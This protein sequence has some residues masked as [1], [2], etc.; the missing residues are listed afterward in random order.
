VIG[1]EISH[2]RVVEK[3]GE[4]GMGIVFKAE[5]VKLHR[6]VALKFLPPHLTADADAVARFE[7]EARAAAALNHPN[8]IGVY[9][10][11]E[12]EGQIYICMEYLEGE[13]LAG[14]LKGGPLPAERAAEIAVQIGAGLSKAHQVGIVH[15]D[16]KPENIF[17][18]HD[19]DVKILDFGLAKLRGVSGLTKQSSTVGTTTYMSPEQ[20]KG[21][22]IDQR[23]DIWSLGVVLYEMIAGHAPFTGDYDQAVAYS[24][25]NEN[26]PPLSAS[27]ADVSGDLERIVDKALAK[28]PGDRY[29]STD[30]MTS[31]LRWLY[32]TAEWSSA[33]VV[34]AGRRASRGKTTAR[35]AVAAAVVVVAGALMAWWL[36]GRRQDEGAQSPVSAGTPPGTR[37]LELK[38]VTFSDGLEEYP[39]LAPDGRRIAYCWEKDGFKQVIV[40]DLTSGS[41]KQITNG[42]ADHIQPAWSPDA[43]TIVYVR[44]NNADGKLEPAD[45]FGVHEDGDVWRQDLDGGKEQKLLDGAFN[46]V[47]SPDGQRIAVD[48]SWAGARRIWV[49]DSYGRNPQQVTFDSSEAV[50][51]IDPDWSPDGAKIVFVNEDWTQFD[52][53]VVDLVTR[54]MNWIT[55]DLYQDLNPVWSPTGGGVYFSSDR[56]G[57]LNVWR[58]PTKADGT[59]FTP[60]QQVTTGAGQDVQLAMSADGKRLAISILGINA[61]LWRLPVSPRTGLPEGEPAPEGIITTTREDSRGAWSPDG[62]RIA[63]N[64]DRSGDMNIWVYSLEDETSRQITTGPGGDYQANWSPDGSNLAF[65]SSRAGNADIWIVDV[66]SGELTQLTR[67]LSLDI[68]PFFSPDGS[69]IAY[70]SD[71]DGRRELWVTDRNGERHR[72]LTNIGVSGH[73]M[74]WMP[75][76]GYVVFRSPQGPS[77]QIYQIAADGGDPEPFVVVHG[78][79]HISFSPNYDA[80]M[81]VVGHKKLWV[82]AVPDG[83]AR[84]V[85]EFDD[86]DVRIDY[87]VWS[88]DGRWVLFDRT[89]PSGGDIWLIENFQ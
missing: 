5:D 84:L 64:S 67:N 55:N 81:D 15:R 54:E 83:D 19:G 52:I 26:H 79:A 42:R 21:E 32:R 10:L 48:A 75:G 47:F 6:T 76:G 78:G 29:E 51:Q 9:D 36:G 1:R 77:G 86:P 65:F 31:D 34:D 4:G 25:I 27:A 16:I 87:P 45:V 20:A 61:D 89:K 43:K 70:Q 88:P 11:G 35:A 59:P 85:F 50:S 33:G 23:T 73:F 71:R 3:I 40:K 74:R 46:P 30:Q 13:D 14:V 44:A 62:G 17:V 49:A 60:P 68:N 69:Q 12:F 80:I 39:A 22:D 18:C 41:E 38:Q 72:R 57:G 56:G 28:N 24:I 2:Y 8:I 63:F 58:V 37:Q 53:K 82:T 7:H 66:E